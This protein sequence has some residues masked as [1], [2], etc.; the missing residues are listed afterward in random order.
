MD[1]T[2]TTGTNAG[3]QRTIALVVLVVTGLLSLPVVAAV[4]DGDSTDQLVVP[5]QLL[6]MAVEGGVVGYLLPG[7]GGAGSTRGR[8]AAVGVVIGVVLALV[9]L[10]VFYLLLD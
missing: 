10:A 4:A 5:L 9:S 8:S 3:T 1:G 2:S 6:L 7:L